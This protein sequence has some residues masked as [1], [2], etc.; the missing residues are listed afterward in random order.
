MRS[1][2]NSLATPEATPERSYGLSGLRSSQADPG[3]G[4]RP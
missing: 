2:S 3:P 4:G 1:R